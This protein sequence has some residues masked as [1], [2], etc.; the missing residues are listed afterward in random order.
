MNNKIKFFLFILVG[1]IIALFDYY[2]YLGWQWIIQYKYY[3]VGSSDG[4]NKVCGIMFDTNPLPI[5][6]M[7]LALIVITVWYIFKLFTL[8]LQYLGLINVIVD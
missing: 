2:I 8:T 6:I 1:L 7:T 4:I 3:C 5:Q